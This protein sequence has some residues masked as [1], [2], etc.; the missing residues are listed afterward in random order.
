MFG[1][2]KQNKTKKPAL[3]FCIHSC[4]LKLVLQPPNFPIIMKFKIHCICSLILQ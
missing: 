2:G 1:E 3:G 4:V